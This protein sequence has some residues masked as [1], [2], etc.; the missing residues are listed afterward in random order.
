MTCNATTASNTQVNGECNSPN[1]CRSE[2]L[3]SGARDGSGMRPKSVNGKLCADALTQPIRGKATSNKYSKKCV[4][5]ATFCN[6]GETVCK[7]GG[8]GLIQR[9]TNRI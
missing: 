6:S 5:R 2:V 3:L 9:Q 7:G 4:A 1:A 8:E